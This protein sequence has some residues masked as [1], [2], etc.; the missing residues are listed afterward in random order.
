MSSNLRIKK[1]CQFCCDEFIAKTTKTKYCSLRCVRKHY[2]VRQKQKKIED[3][4]AQLEEQRS[5]KRKVQKEAQLQ[6][7]KEK[8]IT[9]KQ[10]STIFSEKFITNTSILT[11]YNSSSRLNCN[12]VMYDHIHN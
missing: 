5:T 2:K 12:S 8:V 3:A 9:V 6:L 7:G 1:I 11:D 10:A 4:K